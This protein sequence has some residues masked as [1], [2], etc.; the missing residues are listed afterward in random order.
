MNEEE[1][2]RLGFAA[3][4][5]TTRGSLNLRIV[6][7]A[8][9]LYLVY[10]RGCTVRAV[11][12]EAVRRPKGKPPVHEPPVYGES[13]VIAF[14]SFASTKKLT[15]SG[16]VAALTTNARIVADMLALRVTIHGT[17]GDARGGGARS[18]YRSQNRGRIGIVES[19]AIGR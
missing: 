17:D 3:D 9:S 18:K 19:G 2:T 8:L 12:V 13:A 10:V 4:A 15:Y 16:Y 14:R 6:A 5:P 1:D 11:S 7:V